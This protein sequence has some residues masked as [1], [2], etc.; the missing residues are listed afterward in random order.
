MYDIG[1]GEG[2]RPLRTPDRGE[3]SPG[4][5]ITPAAPFSLSHDRALDGARSDRDEGVWTRRFI[6]P[7]LGSA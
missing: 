2:L 1:A 4:P 7:D 5:S 6:G 3:R